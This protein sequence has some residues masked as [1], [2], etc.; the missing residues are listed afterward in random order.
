MVSAQKVV[1]EHPANHAYE[2][3]LQRLDNGTANLLQ[4]DA[5]DRANFI[6][7][8]TAYNGLKFG[9]L[10]DVPLH[11]LQSLASL[12][13]ANPG[14]SSG[15]LP[16]VA[17]PIANSWAHPLL[18]P[19]KLLAP[20]IDAPLADHSFLLNLALCDGFYF[21]GLA[22]QGGPF[23]NGRTTADLAARF[24]AGE[25][26]DDP[27]LLPHRPNGRPA[28]GLADTCAATDGY[29]RI[30]AWQLLQGPF[31][32]NSTSVPAWLAMLASIHDADALVN[33]LDKAA[34]T[35]RLAPLPESAA[36]EAR[37]SRFRLPASTS[38]A[39]GAAP[40]DAYWLGPREFSGDELKTLAEHIVQQV[41]RRG[42][43]LS[44]AEF[45]NR[46]LTDD[47]LGRCGALQQAIDDAGLNHGLAA[48]AN[49]GFE[50]PA[51]AVANY[52]YANPAAGAG[53]S[54]QGAPGFLS[55][56]DILT[57][58][59]NAATARSDSFTIRACG[60]ARDASGAVTA[61]AWCEAA[62]QRMPEWLDPADPVEAAPA[63]LSAPANQTFGR[64]FL[65]TS[66]R[67][68]APA[69]V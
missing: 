31:N 51:T 29:S 54:Y 17:Q 48:A 22:E 11:P 34:A 57:V 26:L 33:Q 15:F 30:A 5:Q 64:R 32:I 1:S 67:W 63:A 59:G 6:T 37:I 4:I 24:A 7:G 65:V 58:L 21:S 23:G 47:E 56:A 36:D 53:P 60:E 18:P 43:F 68:L 16:R 62:V 44:L 2:V 25:P 49:A 61:T 27:R 10:Y 3:D 46:R 66:F 52:N 19:A 45:V 42:P 20:G 38:A 41:R 55:Q 28:A 50:I 35:S 39:D 12:N 9:A 40:A 69:E 8:H 13:G 14:G